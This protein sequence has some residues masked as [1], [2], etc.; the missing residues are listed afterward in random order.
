MKALIVKS[1]VLIVL[2]CLSFASFSQIF[3]ESFEN[4]GNIPA[5]WT[6]DQIQG[7]E[8]WIFVTEG[9]QHS[10][11]AHTGTYFAEFH[12]QNGTTMLITPSIDLS[13]AVTPILRFWYATPDYQGSQYHQDELT[14]YYRT[15]AGGQWNEM[16]VLDTD[17]E[18]WTQISLPLTDLTDDYYIAFE[19]WLDWAYGIQLDDVTI[20]E[21]STETDFLTF[22]FAE[23]TG[24]AVI[25]DV[26]HTVDIVVVTGTD[27]SQLIADFT[28]SV[29]A[30]AEIGG[31]PQ[32]SG[33]TE[34]DFTDPVT[35][36]IFAEDEAKTTQDWT[37]TVTTGPAPAGSTCDDPI[38]LSD[39]PDQDVVDLPGSTDIYG[40]DY[41]TCD[42][43]DMYIGGNDIVYEFTLTENGYLSG[44][45]G[46]SSDYP[47]IM[48][49]DACPGDGESCIAFAGTGTG[50]NGGSFSDEP[51]GPGTYFVVISNGDW[52]GY[53]LSGFILNLSFRSSETDILSYSFAEQTGPGVID[54]VNH[55]VDIEVALGSD[56]TNLVATF[57]L[58]D[59]A[60]AEIGGTPQESGVTANDF[61]NP[62]TY[63]VT[64]EDGFTDQDWIITVTEEPNT[65]TDILAYSFPEQTGPAAI[66]DVNHTV[67]I[68]VAMGTDVSQLIADFTLSEG[69]D[70]DI[71]GTPQQ[72]GVTENDFTNPVTYTVTSEDGLNVQ[73]W[74]VTVTI[75]TSQ[76]SENDILAYSFAEQTGPATIDDV[77][78][79]VDIEVVNG[80]DV[81]ALIATFELSAL[82]SAEIGGTPQESG[83]TEND[84]SSAV[85]Y[86]VYAEDG[87]PQDWVVT[88]TIAPPPTG[89]T[90]DDPILLSDFPEQ[91]VIDLAGTTLGYGDDYNTCDCGDGYVGNED[92]VYQFTLPYAGYISGS[93]EDDI[94]NYPYINIVDAC[95]GDGETCIV[96][97]GSGTGGTGGSF[98][99]VQIDAGTYFVVIGNWP[100]EEPPYVNFIMNLSFLSSETDI[101]SYSFAEQTGPA[102]IDDVNHTVDIEVALGTDVSGLVATFTLSD[103]ATADIGG[104]PQ[105]SGVTAN[106][107]TNPVTYTVTAE[108]GNTTQDWLVTVTEELNNETD[109][110][111]YSLPEQTGAA[112]IDDVNH[113]VDIEVA[114]GT[115]PSALVASFT[116]SEGAT[117]DIGGTPQ[118]SGVTANDLTNP[119]T[120]TITAEDGTTTQDWIITVTVSTTASGENDILT[121]SFPEQT[122]AATIDDVNHTVDIEVAFGTDPSALVAT[123]TISPLADID[124]GGTP[125]ESGVTVNDFTNPVTYTVTAEDNTPQDWIVTVT[126]ET[127]PTGSVCEDPII[128]S[129]FPDQD[130][131]DLAGTTNGYYDDYSTSDCGNNFVAGNDIVYQFTLPEDG[132]IS[133]SIGGSNDYPYISISD[134]CPGTGETCIVSAG[135]GTGGTGGSFTN[136]PISAGTYFVI[137]SNWDGASQPYVDFIMNLSLAGSGT[138]IL[139]YT[140]PEQTGPAVIDDVNHT[141]D[142]EVGYGTDM[143]NLTATFT[144]SEGATADIGGTPQESGVTANDFTNP[145]TYT[146]TAED[147]INTQDWVITVTEYELSNE[148]DILTYSFPEQTGP[149]TID[150]VNHTVDIEVAYGT[151]VTGLIATFTL[152]DGADATV[153]ATPQVSGVTPNDF[154]APVAYTITAENGT[155][156]QFW[157]ITVTVAT[158]NTETDILTY[159][160][161]EQTGPAVI[162]DVNHTVDIEV[163]A[164][165]GLTNLTATF[166][167]SDGATADIGGTPQVSGVTANDFSNP[168]TYTVTAEDETTTQDWVVTVTIEPNHET[169]ILA[170]SFAEQYSPAVIDDVN[171]TV[172]IEVDNGTDLANLVATFTLSN[173]ATADI[174]G[175]PQVSGVTAND[176]TNP[177]TYTVTAEDGTTTQ[178]WVITVTEHQLNNETDILT[179]SF[180]EETGPAV[181]DNGGHTVTIEVAY[182]TDVTNLIATFT[183]SQ[184]ATATIGATPQVSGVTANNFSAPVVY[185]V[186]AENGTDNQFWI[187]SVTVA[188]ASAETD[189]LTYSFA[190]QTG[191]AVIDDVN[192][193]VDI[194]VALGTDLSGLVATFTLSTGATADIGGTPQV[195]SVT[196]NDFTNPVTY[197]VTAEDGTT[198][199]DWIVTVALAP[200]NETDIVAYS[201]SE[202]TGPATIDDVNHTVDIEVAFGSDLAN[203]VATYTLS[204]GA[205]A[206]IGGTAQE[207]GVTA[208]DFTNPVT[209]TVT[210]QDGITTQDW[211]ITVTTGQ[212]TATDILTYSFPEQTGPATI[213]DVNHTV[214]IEVSLGTDLSSL[215]A[216]FTLSAGATADIGGTP[217]E[218]G[219]TVNDFTSPVTY[220]V[221]AQDGITTQDWVVTVTIEP[222]HETDI[223]AYSFAEQYSPAVIDDVNHTVDIEV[224]NGTDM[225]SLVATYTLSDGATAD[226]GGTPQVN[227]VTANDFTNPVTYTITAEDGTTTQDWIITVTEHQLNNETDILTYSFPEETGPAVIDNGGHTVTIE[228][229]YGTDVSGLIATFTLSPGASATVGA[230]PQVSGVTTNDFSAPLV[231]TITAENGTD[232]QFWI[233]TVTVAPNDETDILSY[234]FAEQYSPAV[235]DDVNHTVD[236]EVNNGTDLANLIASFTL[237]DGAATDIG[238]TPQES[239]VT[240]NDFTN[241]VTYTVTADDGITTQDWVITVTEHILLTGNDILT[242]SFPEETGPAVIDNGSHT[243]SIE[244]ANGTDVTG[245]IATFTLS[246][247][248]S[249]TIGATPQVSGVTVN[250][251]TNPVVYTVT[252]ENGDPQFWIISVTV[253][254]PPSDETDILTYS[255]AEQTGP[256]TIDDVNHVVDI[257][258]AY[259]TDVTGLI[260]TFT[261]SDGATADIGGT[262][263]ESGITA[264]DFSAPVTYTVTAEDEITTQDW[265]IFVSVEPNHET[266][267]LEYSFAMQ[268]GPATIDDV[269]HTVDIEVAMGTDVTGLTATF[270]LSDGAAADIGG[271]A[272]VSGAT[273]NDFTNPVTYTVTA[274]DGTTTQDWIVTVTVATTQ[275]SEND[276]LAYSFPEETGPAVIDNVNHT[277]TIEVEYGTDVTGLVATFTLSPLASAAIGAVPQVSGVTVNNF[278]NAVVYTVTA[279]DGT[280]QFWIVNVT[281]EAPN[282]GTDIL[283]FS[284]AE[285]TGP[286][287]IN[288]VDHTVD[289]EVATGTNLAALIATFTLSEDAAADIGGTPQESGVTV[290]DFTNPVT[291]TITAQDGITVQ[292]W[293]VTVTEAPVSITDNANALIMNVYPNPAYDHFT[294]DIKMPVEGDISIEFMN[295]TG[296]VIYSAKADNTGVHTETIDVSQLAEGIYLLRIYSGSYMKCERVIVR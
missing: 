22:S 25:D 258:V 8:D 220:T 7:N 257:E 149:A 40:N 159:S 108:D 11:V 121:Y 54:D 82:A 216:T 283:T 112:T 172:D 223:L 2:V 29:G 123:F 88:V 170:Y 171:H 24:P 93:I 66:D 89:S 147:G 118:E 243:V 277:V 128:L 186:T 6:Q 267:I 198:T 142:I 37:V 14:V 177:V 16:I 58:S 31:T 72:S 189:I 104:T 201:F 289:I 229:A 124:I 52:V 49:V 84:F 194:E 203:L 279:E 185:T 144:L 101:L 266:D 268:T 62:V 136:V 19:G 122:G 158:P 187:I 90:C 193:T 46:G 17:V 131:V 163:A 47:Y 288:D 70:A 280:P 92:I 224:N 156:N 249:A 228:V 86:T 202:Q 43:G 248:A 190:E 254:P 44:S 148:T 32:E 95:P 237:S 182:G 214:D 114:F 292:D 55:T 106:D 259:G 265:N 132:Y 99:N 18:E 294:V 270:T 166:T 9:T 245:L 69:A 242:Y 100:N 246:E 281:I 256:A 134:G 244:V 269:S 252:A 109:I 23:Q 143:G 4:D 113:T 94:D 56:E 120:Y 111:S 150:D 117:A 169:D 119:V 251:F 157:I 13:S 50:G 80:T 206:D 38:V 208:N 271:T 264:N 141:V 221:T 204:D 139:T 35:Y 102:V 125:Q 179:Y 5:G 42:C 127:P 231:Y 260:A 291:F 287:V 53:P 130:V 1:H 199:Q 276:I 51:I 155:D 36:T 284:F 137:V 83:I 28:L 262:P 183:L 181:I 116:L 85:T 207:S 64:A 30:W 173:G 174:G 240:A 73:D 78:H 188:P 74:V 178:D 3:S 209:Y 285:Q 238:G 210:A 162:D 236:I 234:S 135:T 152:S 138:D 107:F 233:V 232:S 213:D 33:V 27:V 272:Q 215:T 247:G 235:I 79:T 278:T 250:N 168:V 195:S 60:T 293:I 65:E 184:G 255:F 282:T 71:G 161:A 103:G 145:V 263:Q 219:V 87:T 286:A 164:G 273:A 110:L 227:G 192:H 57:T 160:F 295:I 274:E 218:S 275:S 230:T 167:L 165:T 129:D 34:N 68:E 200:N 217:Q 151:D 140:F 20:E 81:S 91:D 226:I 211:I 239:G 97:A 48:V 191:P 12:G 98:S 15:S 180:P 45:V 61:T 75:A 212:N 63:T 225:A 153:G 67:D 115:D 133:G 77:N 296:K 205:T 96:T 126:V 253:E 39:F 76:S 41:L 261:L 146:I 105:V 21:A 241:P 26:N 197:T 59:G 222:N 175:T 10:I 196:A 290:N 176:F 154:S